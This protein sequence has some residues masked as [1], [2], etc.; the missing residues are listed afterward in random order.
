MSTDLFGHEDY[1]PVKPS[2]RHDL[3]NRVSAWILENDL[4]QK[5]G[6]EVERDTKGRYYRMRFSVFKVVAGSVFVFSP[7][8]IS[9]SWTS[10]AAGVLPG[11]SRLFGCWEEA[12][13]FISLAFKEGRGEDAMLIPERVT[14]RRK[15]KEPSD[16]NEIF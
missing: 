6:G 11:G 9:V 8:Y 7:T 15:K 10:Y 12:E 16:E 5:N 14:K 1:A 2:V 13:A 3:A 4:A